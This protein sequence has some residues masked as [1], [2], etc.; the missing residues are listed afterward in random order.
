[1]KFLSGNC[2]GFDSKA[3]VEAL[4]DI[5][6]SENPFVILLQETKMEEI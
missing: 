1:M 4:R 3:K 6:K 5:I 2:I